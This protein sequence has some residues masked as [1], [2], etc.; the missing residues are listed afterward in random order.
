M[1]RFG[2]VLGMMLALGASLV[3]ADTLAETPLRALATGDE[4]RGWEGV[5]RL[6]LG[7]RG[8]CT[9]ALIAPD[10]ILTAAHCLYDKQTGGRFPIEQMKFLADWRLGRAA[11]YRSIRRAVQPKDYVYSSEDKIARIG[12]D[13]ALLQLD[14]PI[15]LASI[16]PFET[17]T[18]VK[19]GDAVGVVSYAKDRPD[20]P[21]LQ[22]M[23]HVLGMQPGVVVLNCDVDFGSS[24]APIFSIRDGVARI[25]SVVSAKAEVDKTQVSL[26]IS[27]G[28][29]LDDLKAQMAQQ[30]AGGFRQVSTDSTAQAPAPGLQ[31]GGAKFLKP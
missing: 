12:H 15:R 8:F 16:Q 13:L 29:L 10:L 2:L 26:G 25:V 9:A 17:G 5:G 28:G 14:Q 4:S 1:V 19:T 22:Q 3:R 7:T 21:S 23:C 31:A 24:G 30:E 27:L 11:A 20:A 18:D 6:N